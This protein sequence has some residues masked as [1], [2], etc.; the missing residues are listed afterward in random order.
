MSSAELVEA[1]PPHN[2]PSDDSF[3]ELEAWLD[4][5]GVGTYADNFRKAGADLSLLPILSNADLQAMGVA[6]IGAR[7]RIL[8]GIAEQKEAQ[9][10]THSR[11][12]AAA[13][14][15]GLNSNTNSLLCFFSKGQNN[16]NNVTTAQP[17][18][19][20]PKASKEGW[21]HASTA[22]GGKQGSRWGSRAA[23]VHPLRSYQLVGNTN[24]VVDRF[25]NLPP[26]T[27]AN[28][29]WFLTH[30]HA[31]HYKGLNSKF[32]RGLIYCTPATAALARQELRVKPEILREVAIGASFVLEGIRVTFLPANHCP[33]AV[34]ILFQ[35]PFGRFPIL[36]TGDCR[37]S[38]GVMQQLPQLQEVRGHVDL[39]LDTTYCDPQ[40]TF[41]PQAEALSFVVDAVKAEAFNPKTL[42]MF[43][44]YTIGKER[45]YLQAAK[46][47]RCKVYVSA[48]KKKILDCLD[49]DEDE[50]AL[51]TSDDS[52]TSLHAVPLWMITEQH[53]VKSLK[54]YRGRYTNVVGF[55]PTGWTHSRDMSSTKAGR[56]RQKGTVI[57]Y[58][59]PYSEH[60][61][62]NELTEFV[63]WLR[64]RVIIP[65]VNNDGGPKLQRMLTNL[66]RHRH[67]FR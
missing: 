12:I 23:A 2:G 17:K 57:T 22:A 4:G 19:K 11:E 56:R 40:Y 21:A 28:K 18:A 64:P 61:S 9:E 59:V 29:H 47:L 32:N 46:I 41:P 6:T 35:P 8:L 26:A 63:D 51:L 30:F 7:K 5:H 31:D 25:C 66:E 13:G 49:L 54:Y 43:G 60:S 55:K 38:S 3:N 37:L 36:H 39:I 44:S 65:S 20:R 45:L 27:P 48:K 15:G 53:M 58:S 24:F 50:K 1:Q 62:F 34:M 16:T 42:F 33:G 14:G 52:E 10:A 67:H